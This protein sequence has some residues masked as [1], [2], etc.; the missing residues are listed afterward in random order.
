MT[1]DRERDENLRR[2]ILTVLHSAR[3]HAP[4]DSGYTGD[5]VMDQVSKLVGRDMGFR[6]EGHFI[7]LC[8]DLADAGVIERRSVG[9]LHQWQDIRA[10]HHQ[11]AITFK[12]VQLVE[13]LIPPVPGIAD[14]RVVD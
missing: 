8:R 14:E 4:R 7:A 9:K 13:E 6:D 1:E 10:M 5:W 12:G 3:R 2:R 11:Y